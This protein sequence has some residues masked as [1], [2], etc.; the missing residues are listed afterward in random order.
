MQ[1][2]SRGLPPPQDPE[3]L[4]VHVCTVLDVCVILGVQMASSTTSTISC[5]ASRLAVT[6]CNLP[7]CPRKIDELFCVFA[8][9]LRR[10]CLLV[11]ESH[12]IIKR[13]SPI[14]LQT[15]Q[16]AKLVLSAEKKGRP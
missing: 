8:A 9:A 5:L 13:T 15:F 3:P 16:L 7:A 1:V 11:P 10:Q 2:Q 6:Q 14:L 4:S 12:P